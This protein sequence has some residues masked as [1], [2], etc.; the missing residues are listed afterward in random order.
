MLPFFQ[1]QL[2]WEWQV[3]QFTLNG[4]LVIAYADIIHMPGVVAASQNKIPGLFLQRID[5]LFGGFNGLG[6]PVIVT[7]AACWHNK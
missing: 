2:V 4:F 7:E 5:S 6:N 3:K 1:V